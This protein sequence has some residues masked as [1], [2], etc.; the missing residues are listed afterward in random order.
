MLAHEAPKGRPHFVEIADHV[1]Q[2]VGPPIPAYR[3]PCALQ[4]SIQ[5]SGECGSSGNL[6][7]G[8]ASGVPRLVL[9]VKILPTASDRRY[10]RL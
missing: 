10:A 1:E 5:N 4:S 6:M 9:E 3:S 8:P 7:R 2:V